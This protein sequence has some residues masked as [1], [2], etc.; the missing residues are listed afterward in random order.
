MTR[1]LLEHGADPNAL[2]EHGETP[3]HLA[4]RTTILGTRC[5]DA[6]VED[7]WMY[8]APEEVLDALLADHRILVIA[9]DDEGGSHLHCV[10]YG[11]PGTAI[12]VQRLISKGAD[13]SAVNLSQEIPLHL[14]IQ[15]G[16]YESVKVLLSVGASVSWTDDDG[17]NAL[18]C[19]AQIRSPDIALQTRS[20]E[21]L[22]IILEDEHAMAVTLVLSKDINGQNVL[23]HMLSTRTAAPDVQLRTLKWLL[24]Q[25][26]N[27]SELDN[28]GMS[29]LAIYIESSPGVC[30]QL[31]KTLLK[32]EGNASFVSRDGQTLGH[33]CAMSWGLGLSMLRIMHVH[34]VVLARKDDYGRTVL[35]YG[36][37]KGSLTEEPSDFLVDV[38]GIH[39]G[40]EDIHGYTAL[41]YALEAVRRERV[42]FGRNSGCLKQA[43]DILLKYQDAHVE[44]STVE[45]LGGG[46]TEELE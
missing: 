5:E 10:R 16:D 11:K 38:V 4:L 24:D 22:M 18:H 9:I 12:L 26:A 14:A 30:V 43:R 27:G 36:A 3:L 41:K 20:H 21:I 42:V 25:G 2:S 15:A 31:F 1:F 28:F 23:H 29:P 8:P 45:V 39:P 37:L 46:I 19:A 17:L 35:H 44:M 7:P 40:D 32:I 34:G 33:L 13:P 6:W